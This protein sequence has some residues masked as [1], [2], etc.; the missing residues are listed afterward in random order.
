MRPDRTTKTFWRTGVE[1]QALG[2]LALEV[3]L[4][5]SA[6]LSDIDPTLLTP[7]RLP[8]LWDTDEVAVQHVV[9]YFTG[10][11]SAVVPREG[12]DDTV[13]IPKCEPSVVEETIAI[14]VERGIV[15]LINGPASIFREAVPVGLLSPSATLSPPPAPVAVTDLM[16]ASI[17][18]AWRDGRASALAISTSLS[19]NQGKPLPW[20]IVQPAINSAIQTRWIELAPESSPLP[21]DF[22]NA[23]NVIVQ[24]ATTQPGNGRRQISDVQK[25]LGTV[26]AE[27]T[28]EANG[29]QDL[30]DQIPE[31]AMAAVGLQLTFNLQIELSGDS[32]PEPTVVEAINSLLAA[33]S[34]DL[35]LQ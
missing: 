16:E 27:A 28:L 24:A 21:C 15:W 9:D 12:Y 11:H 30:A 2:D 29:V 1:E 17:P 8:G 4:P 20:A 14:A 10:G 26:T 18:D 35:K 19:A 33:V 23:H 3:F 32:P 13:F 34:E 22:G 7:G 6:T 31:M 25:R 5:E